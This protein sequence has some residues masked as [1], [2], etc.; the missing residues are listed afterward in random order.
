MNLFLSVAA[1]FSLAICLIHLIIGGREI[2]R[3]LLAN[4]DLPRISKWTLYMCWHFVT[5]TLAG[6]A[7]A[8]LVS[9]LPGGERTPAVFATAA[10]AIYALTNIGMNIA[11]GLRHVRHPQ[12][13][14][15]APLAGLGAAGLW[16]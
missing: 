12:W 1:V 13:M 5:I 8:Y 10:A 3:P 15:F 2:I 11:L 6:M 16:M 14:L 4:T 9:A 7:I